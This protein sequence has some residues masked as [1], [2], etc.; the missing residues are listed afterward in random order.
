MQHDRFNETRYRTLVVAMALAVGLCLVAALIAL[1]IPGSHWAGA[2]VFL[3][4]ALLILALLPAVFA[5]RRR[6]DRAAL[7]RLGVTLLAIA[8]LAMLQRVGWAALFHWPAHPRESPFRPVLHFLPFLFIAAVALLNARQGLKLCWAAWGAVALTTVVGLVRAGVDPGHEGTITLLA[9]LLLGMPLFLALLHAL[10]RYEDAL[11]RSEQEMARMRERAELMDRLAESERRFNLV[12]DGLQVGVWDRW[13]GPPERRWW[14]PRFYELLGYTPDELPSTEEALKNLLHPDDRDSVWELGTGQLRQGDFLDVNFRLLTK[15]RGYRWF[16]SHAKA[17]RDAG[18]RMRRIAGA[19]ADIH[20]RRSAEQ[21]LREAQAELTQL[22]Y[23]DT[24]T[25]L[26]NRR[27]F[28]EH[29]ERE[30]RRVRRLQEPMSLLLV[31]LDYFKFFND[32]Y[33]HIAGDQCLQQIAEQLECGVRRGT[34]FVARLGGE[35][36]G[37]L[38]PDT[39]AEG[40]LRVGGNLLDSLRSVNIRH[41]AAPLGQVTISIGVAT[42]ELP[43]SGDPRTLFEQAD[44]ALYEVKRRG[45]N[46]VLHARELSSP[47]APAVA[48]RS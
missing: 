41:D 33:G 27:A 24:L 38:L 16:N 1:R 18:G 6:G 42:T 23:R 22:A 32:C 11:E 17:E 12:V 37:I 25:H 35:E 3:A 8:F 39:P 31:D 28:D 40:A 43:P 20:D 30:W 46:G 7:E 48:A 36:F 26:H 10:P 34:D 19:I 21:A 13:I 44:K 4:A 5:A 45:R 14:S 9:Y 29:F 2:A 15:H 47:I